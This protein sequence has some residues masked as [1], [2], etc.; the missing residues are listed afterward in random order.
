MKVL[1]IYPEYPATF[2]SFK[3]ALPFINKKVS[4]PPLG[5]LTVSS[6]LPKE[7]EK[8]LVD[9]NASDLKDEDIKWADYVF[10]SGMVVQRDSAKEVI[11]RAKSFGKTVVAGGPLFTNEYKDFKNVDVFILNEGEVTIPL[12]LKDVENN[13]LKHI[14]ISDEKPDLSRTPVPD[15]FLLNSAHYSSLSMQISRGCPHSCDFCD[16]IIMN[17]R[18]PRLKSPEQVLKE[19]DA[20]FDYGWRGGVFIVDDNFIGNKIGAERILT[21]IIKWMDER[22]KPFTLFTEASINLADDE[23]LMSLMQ[24]A[25]FDSVFIGIETPEEEALIS[26]GKHQN[27]NKDLVEKVKILQR[28][29]LEV[30]G[31]FILGFDSDTQYTFDNMIKFIQK[32]GIVSAMVGLLH[33]I[34]ETVLYKRLQSEKRIISSASCNNTD[35]TLN[36]IP[37]M[38]LD[39][40]MEGYNKVLDTLFAPKYYNK[41]IITYMKEYKKIAINNKLTFRI[42]MKALSKTIWKIGITGKGKFH[43]WKLMLWTILRKPALISEAVTYSIYGYHFRKVL[44][45][46]KSNRENAF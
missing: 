1:L 29:G 9:L 38:K 33:A 22:N 4:L 37:Q 5:L 30:Q 12:F 39:A 43:F 41:R 11:I 25:N 14:Y 35:F 40:L 17:G 32:S 2:W 16:I 28:N 23:K 10:I 15:W 6:L 27:T 34:P 36:F 13:T 7:W 31:G 26:C 19:M 46:N 45:A 42:Q 44:F 18:I 8:K 21:E 20:L 24:K 3:H